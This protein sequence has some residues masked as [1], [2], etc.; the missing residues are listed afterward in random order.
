METRE[1][2]RTCVYKDRVCG[3]LKI[4]VSYCVSSHSNKSLYYGCKTIYCLPKYISIIILSILSI[5]CSTDVV[6]VYIDASVLR[7]SEVSKQLIPSNNTP[8]WLNN[9]IRGALQACE[10]TK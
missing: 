10:H 5:F 6:V 9:L 1:E 8:R 2:E 4:N 3:A 7:F